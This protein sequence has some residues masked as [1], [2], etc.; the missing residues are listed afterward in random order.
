MGARL[1]VNTDTGRFI[2]KRLPRLRDDDLV[3]LVTSTADD[4]FVLAATDATAAAAPTR[5]VNPFTGAS[6]RFSAMI[7]TQPLLTANVVVGPSC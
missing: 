7:P 5:V 3:C 6:I 1:F 4:L 2:Y